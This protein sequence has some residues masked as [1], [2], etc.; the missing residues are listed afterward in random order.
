MPF[1]RMGKPPVAPPQIIKA[2]KLLTL[3]LTVLLLQVSAHST[4]QQVNY[5]V[6]EGKLK[7]AFDNLEKQ[8]GMV[9]FYKSDLLNTAK[10]VTVDL[11]NLPIAKALDQL[12][13][14]QP[15]EY[16]I[17]GNTVFIKPKKVQPP[18]TANLI[19]ENVNAAIDVHGV[20]KDETGKPVVG[21]SVMVKGTNKG[22]TT[23]DQGEFN[24]NAV[25]EKATII[26][27]AV[28][29]ETREILV[30]GRKELNLVAKTKISKLEDVEITAVNTGYQII[31]RDR[32]T[33]S[34]VNIDN[35]LLNRKT[36]TN[37]I[38]RIDGVAAGL[39]VSG[40]AN[41]ASIS[42]VPSDKNTGI[43]IRGISTYRA[44]TQP[45]IVL[46]DFPYEGELNNINPNDIESIT[47]LKDAAA[48]SIWGA[49]SGNGVIVITTKKGK[50]KQKMK[51]E[52]NSSVTVIDKPDLFYAKNF[53]DSKSYIGV[54]QYLFNQG[55]FDPL[56]ADFVYNPALSP[57][58]N[59]LVRQK[60]GTISA[61]DANT[62]LSALSQYDVRND[63]TKYVYQ[64]AINQQYSLGIKGGGNDMTYQLSIGND[65]D[66]NT[67]LRNGYNRTT[68]NST[69]TYSPIK[70]LEL[71]AGINY[72]QSKTLLNNNVGFGTFSAN[73]YP[74]RSIIPYTK[75]ADASGN[76]L[77]VT[78]AYN[79]AY[80]KTIK[81]QG[82]MDWSY[83]PLDELRLG[84][85]DTKIDDIVLSVGGKYKIIPQLSVQLNYKNEHE[86]IRGNN[87][88]SQETYYVRNLINQFG[89]YNSTT[90]V[91][92]F[93]FPLGAV[94]NLTNTAWY[95]NNLRSQFDYNQSF[96]KNAITAIAGAEIRELRTESYTRTSLGYNK[97]N[98]TSVS[99]LNFAQAFSTNP[100]GSGNLP[101]LDGS[102]SGTLNRYISYYSNAAYSYDNKYTLTLSGRKDGT[103]LFGAKPNDRI[104]P[105]WSTGL[106]WTVSKES[107]YHVK[108]LPNLKIRATYG[109]N[110]NIYNGSAFLT[111]T[112]NNDA[113]TGALVLTRPTAP[114]PELRWEKV[115][116]INLGIDFGIK[117]NVIGGTIEFYQKEGRDLIQPTV[118]APQTGFASYQANTA[119]I[120]IHGMDITLQ[121]KNLGGIFKW[122]T[123]LL[124]SVFKDRVTKYDAARTSTSLMTTGGV[125]GKPLEGLFR[126]KWAGL[127]PL[128][129][130]PQGFLNGKISKDYTGIINNF[131]PDSLQY[132]GSIVPTMYGSIRN[133]F[134]YKS[135]S[136]SI[137]IVY[138]LGWVT[139]VASTSLN[140][141]DLLLSGQN[142]DYTQRWQKPGDERNTNVPSLVYPSY[143]DR[144]TFYQNSQ[145][146]VQ[147]ADN[148]RL[149]DVR[150]GYDLPNTILRKLHAT[151]AT[152][153]AYANNL[154]IIWRKNK[155]GI[156]PDAIGNG[157]GAYPN[158]TSISFGFNLN[159]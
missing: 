118:L 24:L 106:G 69:N 55:Y 129:G 46:D 72:S 63:Y 23:N 133:D 67:L 119:T 143:S 22:T 125:V 5:T 142:Q 40:I 35:A 54:E 66:R 102:V 93:N 30:G 108:W 121:S 42:R 154:G 31:P 155:L 116:N 153:Y 92:T 110:G 74:Y 122:N 6:K 84:D 144:N 77:A 65:N 158:P 17:E 50:L 38:D 76:P 18:A 139:P 12:L 75:L 28:N 20:V 27:S 34:F 25:D 96:G 36:S 9:F 80:I 29:I 48:A 4:A 88:Q 131:N 70:N 149:Q 90:G 128:T 146:L 89:S 132:S 145:I 21:A 135:F 104:T 47:I 60:A 64:K 16:T 147:S 109:Y 123:T 136:I 148:I 26:I 115:R 10:T 113:S 33:G 39:Y 140:Y 78:F 1:S 45:L 150:I 105:L 107:F 151:R 37:I 71:T 99:N 138:Q 43:T 95:V 7:D 51:V 79:D 44:S 73:G 101:G 91:T 130:D 117:N 111:A 53:L 94:S 134:S 11:K 124:M 82:L 49:R 15:L 3:F 157:L 57:A 32:A 127:D 86:S 13:K 141:T 97:D 8:T 58:V 81:S 98:G 61:S 159:F 68:I 156:D 120:L 87:Y 103:N 41:I 112:Y 2:M 19:I 114:N 83:S 59:I 137:N 14:D 152:I 52:L 56:L 62:Q 85:N 100:A 126:Y